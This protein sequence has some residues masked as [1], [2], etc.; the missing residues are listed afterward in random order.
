MRLPAAVL[1]DSE[2]AASKIDVRMMME[3]TQQQPAFDRVES[4]EV[5]LNDDLQITIAPE[6]MR[7]SNWMPM[8]RTMERVRRIKWARMTDWIPQMMKMMQQR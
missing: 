2:T 5:K 7:M 8:M 6:S 4:V 3:M 1:P